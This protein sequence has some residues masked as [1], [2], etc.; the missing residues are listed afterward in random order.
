VTLSWNAVSD[1]V[2]YNI[3][4]GL[5][6]KKIYHNYL[7]Y[8]KTTIDINSLRAKHD[9]WFTI[10]AFNEGGITEG[11]VLVESSGTAR[12]SGE[13]IVREEVPADTQV[14]FHGRAPVFE[15]R[16]WYMD[17]KWISVIALACVAFPGL[18]L[19]ALRRRRVIR[20]EVIEEA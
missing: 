12:S 20:N 11:T 18:V 9:Y 15:T 14:V 3:R 6:S 8:D 5:D 10:D 17:A 16:S 13:K 19:M 2:G 1:A 4:F 7:V